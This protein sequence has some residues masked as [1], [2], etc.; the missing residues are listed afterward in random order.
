MTVAPFSPLDPAVYREIVRRA[1]AEDVRWG[2]VATDATISAELTPCV[3]AGVDV[4]SECFRQLDPHVLTE[5]MLR[6]G[7]HC[8]SGTELL[9]IRGFASALLTAER[10]ALNFLQRMCAVA[11]R[12]RTYV[13]AGGG[14]VTVLDTRE[15]TPTLRALE[16]YAVR[17]GGGVNHRVGLDDGA[18]VER[19]HAE[20][21][22]GITA[23]VARIREAD[24]DL[25]IEVE[26]STLVA[27]DEAL[28]VGASTVLVDGRSLT[29]VREAVRRSRGRAKVEITGEVTP[30][31]MAEL[32]QTG[33]EYV[34]VSELTWCVPGI[35]IGL[36]LGGPV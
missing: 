4:A 15:T 25:P 20:L 11:T 29:F 2:D 6:D 23:A 22:G 8:E 31:R 9:R 21:A 13:E 30:A 10:T 36:T 28:A 3:L 26:T 18:R 7:V 32:S 35:D 34:S 14:R 17:V 16:T 19:H 1:L 5:A 24:A 33:A 27:V 12:A